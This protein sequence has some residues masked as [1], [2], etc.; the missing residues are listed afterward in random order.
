[1][2]TRRCGRSNVELP[3]IG[4]GSMRMH[5][6]DVAHWASIVHEAMLAGFT[7][8]DAG[9]TYCSW[10]NETKIGLGIKGIPREDICLSTKCSGRNNPTASEVRKRIDESLKRLD[11]GYL[12][13]YQMWG[14]TWREFT[15]VSTKPGGTLE[16]IRKAMSEGLIRHL[17]LTCHDK[18]ENMIKLL[19]T[20]EFEAITLQYNLL[21]RANEGVIAEAG[22]LGVGVVVMSPL[23]GGILACDSPLVRTVMGEGVESTEEAAFRFVLSNPSVTC[24]ISGMLTP[25]EIAKDQRIAER[26]RPFTAAERKAADEGLAKLEIESGKLCTGCRYCMPCPQG[27][28][29]SEVFRLANTA[30][31]YGAV[32]GARRDYKLFSV[33]WPYDQWKDGSHCTNCGACVEKCPQKI[34]VPSELKKAHDALK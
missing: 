12:D 28:G 20:G 17:G 24:A 16:G 3:V 31:V 5:G 18:P 2:Q 19:A 29:I 34:D 22:R 4:F 33:D 23:K 14:L 27:I 7:Y 9:N 32:E 11:V 13:F 1:M 30:R 26:F 8:I 10:T 15:E 25:E 6:D 21:D